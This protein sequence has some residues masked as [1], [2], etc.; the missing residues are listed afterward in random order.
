MLGRGASI[1]QAR[2]FTLAEGKQAAT[3]RQRFFGYGNRCIRT[4]TASGTRFLEPFIQK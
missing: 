1:I 3:R 2:S 4:V